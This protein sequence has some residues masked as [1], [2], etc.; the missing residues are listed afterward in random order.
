M[1]MH[2]LPVTSVRAVHCIVYFIAVMV[3]KHIYL[4]FLLIN[5]ANHSVQC[6]NI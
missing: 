3:F 1:H 4:E 2:V 6:A 5:C